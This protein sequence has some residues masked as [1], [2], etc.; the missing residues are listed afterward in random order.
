MREL[1]VYIEIVG[2][3][4]YVGTIKGKDSEDA[5]F[6]YVDEYISSD[7]PCLL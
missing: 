3:W 5:V 7:N 4:T 1:K 6:T 2:N